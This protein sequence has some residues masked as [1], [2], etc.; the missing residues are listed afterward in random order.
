MRAESLPS[1]P[2]LDE[3]PSEPEALMAAPVSDEDSRKTGD[4]AETPSDAER[5][6][7]GAEKDDSGPTDEPTE[8]DLNNI[9]P[10]VPL[11]IVDEHPRK[12]APDKGRAPSEASKE[13]E[14][15][16]V[17]HAGDEPEIKVD[18]PVPPPPDTEELA[19][20]EPET[21]EVM[22]EDEVPPEIPPV[23]DT[24]TVIPTE[25]SHKPAFKTF[26]SWLSGMAGKKDEEV[27]EEDKGEE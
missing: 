22:S 9:P 18:V 8:I 17:R 5:M 2:G 16:P 27:G 25:E 14:E 20:V 1:S 19:V 4:A 15:P 10:A 26:S 13:G 21:V 6:K 11:D 12:A 23:K 3:G 24:A 7:T